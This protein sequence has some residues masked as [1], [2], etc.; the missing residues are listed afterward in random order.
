M[1]IQIPDLLGVT[2]EPKSATAIK[3][4]KLTQG[5]ILNERVISRD[6]VHKRP[7]IDRNIKISPFYIVSANVI[8]TGNALTGVEFVLQ[9]PAKHTHAHPSLID[10]KDKTSIQASFSVEVLHKGLIFEK[11]D[12][13]AHQMDKEWKIEFPPGKKKPAAKHAAKH[14]A[15]HD[16]KDEAKKQAFYL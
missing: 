14:T 2:A 6:A 11:L 10:L 16:S 15:K 8:R 3:N 12:S 7:Q 4:A 1:S 5:V 13:T 9:R